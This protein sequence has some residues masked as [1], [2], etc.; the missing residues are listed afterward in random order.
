M[1]TFVSG[2]KSGIS[3]L[4]GY[5]HGAITSNYMKRATACVTCIWIGLCATIPLVLVAFALVP[6]YIC[7]MLMP[8]LSAAMT[9]DAAGR[10]RTMLDVIHPA[11]DKPVQSYV[12]KRAKLDRVKAADAK[13]RASAPQPYGVRKAKLGRASEKAPVLDDVATADIPQPEAAQ[14]A[15]AAGGV[16][17]D[18]AHGRI[19]AVTSS[20]QAGMATMGSAISNVGKS[21]GGF[22][23]KR[24]K[25]IGDQLLDEIEHR[26]QKMETVE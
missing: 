13:D 10:M 21:I 3:L 11:S 9:K 5:A 16:T 2:A 7:D 22:L 25:D 8:S 17:A 18:G 6:L 24:E 14:L 20:A 12:V 15:E 4:G 26:V 1:E 19:S 23:P